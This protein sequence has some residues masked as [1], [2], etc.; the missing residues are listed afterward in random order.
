MSDT[1]SE[2]R[3]WVAKDN[4][5][6]DA[7]VERITKKKVESKH[8]A[9]LQGDDR[10]NLFRHKCVTARNLG[11]ICQLSTSTSYSSFLTRF[12]KGEVTWRQVWDFIVQVEGIA[13]IHATLFHHAMV[14]LE[15]INDLIVREEKE[16][17]TEN[18]PDKKKEYDALAFKVIQH[19]FLEWADTAELDVIKRQAAA[20]AIPVPP[21]NDLDQA[22]RDLEMHRKLR[23]NAFSAA[24]ETRKKWKELDTA[25]KKEKQKEDMESESQ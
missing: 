15:H 5:C 21:Y 6:I 20:V 24:E 12:D 8:L 18:D 9:N 25:L 2:T 10:R 7:Y 14:L 23:H 22:K 3:H 4:E 16:D 1:S 13:F 11:Q 17:N 19:L